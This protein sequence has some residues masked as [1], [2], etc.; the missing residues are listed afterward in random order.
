MPH[1]HSA[2]HMLRVAPGREV[3]VGRSVHFQANNRIYPSRSWL[4]VVAT[5]KKGLDAGKYD[6]DRPAPSMINVIP[7]TP[8]QNRVKEGGCC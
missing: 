1:A 2:C 5:V 4:D 6:P 3:C 8:S 7:V